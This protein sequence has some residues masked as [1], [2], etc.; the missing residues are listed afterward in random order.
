M[1][2]ED[3]RK[4]AELLAELLMLAIREGDFSKTQDYLGQIEEALTKMRAQP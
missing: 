2:R 3:Y 4:R 1:T